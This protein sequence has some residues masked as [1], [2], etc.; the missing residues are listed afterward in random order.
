MMPMTTHEQLEELFRTV[1]GDDDLTLTDETT[2]QDI[3]AWDSVASI[4]LMFA[5]ESEFNMQ[6]DSHGLNGFR[7]IGELKRYIESN[8]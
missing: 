4:N 8:I 3:D 7:N 1:F 6:F 5:I 2:A